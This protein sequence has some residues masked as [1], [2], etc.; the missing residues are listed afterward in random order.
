MLLDIRGKKQ[1]AT[2]KYAI[3][4]K[5]NNPL[6]MA[7]ILTFIDEESLENYKALVEQNQKDEQAR[8][9]EK[10]SRLERIVFN[11]ALNRYIA[12]FLL[13]KVEMTDEDF[14]LVLATKELKDMPIAFQEIY[15]GIM[16]K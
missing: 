11:I 14:E 16:G 12:M 6:Q 7:E 13:G 4:K 15:N 9:K 8:E 5:D 2:K 3:I 10:Q 1:M